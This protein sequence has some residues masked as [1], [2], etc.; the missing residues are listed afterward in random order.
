MASGSGR[1]MAEVT[2]G[3]GSSARW[4]IICGAGGNYRAEL[5]VDL[6][7]PPRCAQYWLTSGTN[8]DPLTETYALLHYQVNQHY[9][10]FTGAIWTPASD[11]INKLDTVPT[12]H[13]S[14]LPLTSCPASPGLLVA[15]VHQF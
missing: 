10:H 8:C 4:L 14:I 11:G 9:G 5:G 12:T 7:S 3:L 1:P 15:L 6:A 13:H 2:N